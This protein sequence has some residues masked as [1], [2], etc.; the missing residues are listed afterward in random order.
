MAGCV[1]GTISKRC[2]RLS[3]IGAVV[4][5]LTGV[6]AADAGDRHASSPSQGQ[7]VPLEDFSPG[8][9]PRRPNVDNEYLPLIPG[10]QWVFEGV[11]NRAS[12]ILPHRVT[13]TVTDLVKTI[14][15]VSTRIVWDVDVNQGVLYEA[16]L[17]FFAQDRDGNVWNLGEYPEEYGRDG[18]GQY[19]FRGAPNTW[20]AGQDGAQAGIHMRARPRVQGFSYLQGFAPTIDFLDCATV[21]DT[22]HEL[23]VPVAC[24][25]DVVVTHET[26]P[27]D[28]AG[29]T[30]IKHHAPGTGIV[31]VDALNDPEGEELVLV[32]LNHLDR[33][34]SRAA[35]QEALALESR[36][37][38]ISR[39]YGTTPPARRQ[40]TSE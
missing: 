36:A 7:C 13:F 26:S 5:L 24:Y 25:D 34:E 15:G 32:A 11:A 4:L 9:F 20:I 37:Y 16:E 10:T 31:S 33:D 30:Q 3:T 1:S 29:G 35:R 40:A 28:P 22:D 14:N 23:C 12:G 18:F 17:A 39:V 27:L 6:A 38:G 19:G 8:G 2:A 21:V